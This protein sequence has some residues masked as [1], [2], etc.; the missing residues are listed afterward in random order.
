MIVDRSARSGPTRSH[1]VRFSLWKNWSP[2]DTSF[3]LVQRF[4]CCWAMWNLVCLSVC[5]V[6]LG[7]ELLYFTFQWNDDNVKDIFNRIK[8]GKVTCTR[9]LELLEFFRDEEIYYL[10]VALFQQKWNYYP[11]LKIRFNLLICYPLIRLEK[12]K[13]EILDV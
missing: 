9:G 13:F 12:I 8:R 6:W 5:W 4:R 11:I 7:Q 2:L 3:L 1:V 10:D